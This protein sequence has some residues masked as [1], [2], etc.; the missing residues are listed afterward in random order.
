MQRLSRSDSTLHLTLNYAFDSKIDDQV[1]SLERHPA[2][3]R[4]LRA[5]GL[6]PRE[7]VILTTLVGSGFI[8]LQIADSAGTQA[9]PINVDPSLLAFM[10]T[11][12]AEFDS[13]KHLLD[14]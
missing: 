12:R 11:H 9:L 3:M 2:A 7:F 14:Q 5:H 6:T 10:T 8:M 4:I 1:A 13:L